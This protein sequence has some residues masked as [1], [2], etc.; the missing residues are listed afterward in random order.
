MRVSSQYRTAI[1]RLYPTEQQEKLLLKAEKEVLKFLELS[2]FELQKMLYHKASEAGVNVSKY[3][4][5]LLVQRFTGSMGE[6]A[7]IPYNT[8][9]NA[10]FVNDNGIWFLEVQLFA[11]KGNR[12]RIPLAKSEVPYYSVL[13]ELEGLPILIARENSDWFAYVSIPVSSVS[14][15]LVVGVDFNYRKWVASPYD[16]KPVFF[17]V[18]EYVEKID[19]LQK[20]ASRF[21]SRKEEEKVQECHRLI[22]ETVKLAHGNFLSEIKDSYGICTIAMEDVEKMY[23]MV[24]EI[25]SKMTNNWLNTK[26]ALRQFILR[27]M[28]KGF[29]IMEVDP[30]NTSRTCHRCGNPVKIYGKRGRLIS[31]ASCGYRDYSRD[32][33]AARN[34]ARRGLVEKE[35]QN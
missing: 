14:D 20:M 31:C 32:L 11:G 35:Q 30:K 34:I 2:R 19:R 18:M 10:K 33:N 17:D 12:V 4:I 25:D 27:A 8:E 29:E 23:R 7:I 3:T 24:E 13:D 21:Q 28:A 16:G 15:G 9:Y 1:V 5:A 22:R 6:K 26:T